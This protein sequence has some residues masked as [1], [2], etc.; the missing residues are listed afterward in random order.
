MIN[1]YTGHSIVKSADLPVKIESARM[2]LRLDDNA[3]DD[4]YVQMVVRALCD[5]VER[6]YNVAMLT[7]TVVEKHCAFPIGANAPLYVLIKP[8][9]S[10]TSIG[11]IDSEG[12]AQVLSDSSYDVV[13]NSSG[14]Y[15]V[16]KV[17]FE[18]PTDLSARPDAVTV[19]YVA[20]YGAG[21]SSVPPAMSLA[22]LN[23]LGKMDANREDPVSEKVT[24][25][26]VLL[27]PFYQFKA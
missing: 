16:P 11:Y 24:A 9:V 7:Q 27:H 12:D 20:G 21:P 19:T 13:T 26:D 4:D 17:D 18:W 22:I 15:I 8:G 10:V 6:V 3:A 23:K 25:S 1:T 2:Q 14:M 5:D